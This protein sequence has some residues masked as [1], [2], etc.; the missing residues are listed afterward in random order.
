MSLT[1]SIDALKKMLLQG[2]DNMILRFGLGQALLKAGQTSEAIEHLQ[3][4]LEFDPEYSAA[5]KLL[6]KARAENAEQHLAI[7]TYEKGIC[8]AEKKGDIQAAK[9]MRV[10]LKRLLKLQ[11]T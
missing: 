5:W 10:F 11:N 8:I 7:E 2:Q 3:A 9:E 6:G 4:A 1:M